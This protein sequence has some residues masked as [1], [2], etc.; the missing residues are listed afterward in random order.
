M[1]REYDL[2]PPDSEVIIPIKSWTLSLLFAAL[3]IQ[4]TPAGAT[5]TLVYLTNSTNADYLK[6][7]FLD[8]EEEI[9]PLL[10]SGSG[11]G[12]DHWALLYGEWSL[13]RAR[14]QPVARGPER[15]RCGTEHLDWERISVRSGFKRVFLCALG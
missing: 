11:G 15:L 3:S 5:T 2:P 7:T 1:R 13:H 10:T 8:L 6:F 4:A 12:W 14:P 9:P